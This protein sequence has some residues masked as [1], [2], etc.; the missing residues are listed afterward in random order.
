MI[1]YGKNDMIANNIKRKA[2]EL[3][4]KTKQLIEKTMKLKKKRLPAD[5]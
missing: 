5:K 4:I 3:E 1:N 2:M